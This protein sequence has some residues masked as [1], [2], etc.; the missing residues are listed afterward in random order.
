M[1]IH[2][3]EQFTKMFSTAVTL[4]ESNEKDKV[5]KVRV[6]PGGTLK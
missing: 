2:P 6:S 1:L 3:I 4:G 5:E